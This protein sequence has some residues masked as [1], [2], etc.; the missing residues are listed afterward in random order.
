VFPEEFSQL[1]L[2]TRLARL[3]RRA[4]A[5]NHHDFLV[6]ETRQLNLSAVGRRK[7]RLQFGLCTAESRRVPPGEIRITRNGL[8]RRSVTHFTMPRRTYL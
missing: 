6:V 1:P 2:A 5:I 3:H 8:V 4:S 7:S